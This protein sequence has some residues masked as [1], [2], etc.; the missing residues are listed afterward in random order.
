MIGKLGEGSSAIAVEHLVRVVDFDS[1]EERSVG[2]EIIPILIYTNAD[3]VRNL[4]K[5]LCLSFVTDNKFTLTRLT[6]VLLQKMS[7]KK[8]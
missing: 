5:Q 4:R 1:P 6:I 7:K 3:K 2:L 8:M